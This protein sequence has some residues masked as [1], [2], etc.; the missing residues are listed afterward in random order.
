M[1]QIFVFDA[2]GMVIDRPEYFSVHYARTHN[3]D[4]QIMEDFFQNKFTD[5][6]IDKADLEVEIEPFLHLWHLDQSPKEFLKEWFKTENTPNQEL[7]NL[8]KSLRSK[9][10]PCY[11]ATNQE[12]YRAF[13][14]LET[15][16]LQ[17]LF[18]HCFFSYE[19]GAKKP[20][21]AFFDYMWESLQYL[22]G[23]RD[24]S[25]VIFWDDQ[26]KNTEAAARF[27]FN[28]RHYT[29]LS[30]FQDILSSMEIKI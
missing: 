21:T 13:Y 19:I 24:K 25:Q 20:S 7:I 29:S 23:V 1:N 5:C 11:L 2:D 10:I 30:G 3:L 6:L 12:K 22:E 9:G 27:G 28:A 26:A 4:P 17:H 8:I 14:M 16:K 15:M 18:D